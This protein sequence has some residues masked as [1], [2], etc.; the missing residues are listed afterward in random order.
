MI[1]RV[2]ILQH[3]LCSNHKYTYK[4]RWCKLVLYSP[5]DVSRV[6]FSATKRNNVELLLSWLNRNISSSDENNNLETQAYMFDVINLPTPPSLKI[7]L[8]PFYAF[9]R[10][11]SCFIRTLFK[12]VCLFLNGGKYQSILTH[13]QI[14]PLKKRSNLKYREIKT[15]NFETNLKLYF[16]WK[17]Y[18]SYLRIR[19]NGE[20]KDF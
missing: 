13:I 5:F 20:T 15:P 8:S 16:S 11:F 14:S 4:Y 18:C 17:I 1:I 9:L 12:H 2:Y 19:K 3:Y 10:F 6:V 7:Q